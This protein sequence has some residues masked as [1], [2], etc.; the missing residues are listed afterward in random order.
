MRTTRSND[1]H[2][3]KVNTAKLISKGDE[4]IRLNVDSKSDRGFSNN[5]F[6]RMLIPVQH[7]GAYD[8]DPV[9]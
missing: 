1:I 5:L 7:I 8:S 6:G 4:Q 3:L 9:G 2:R